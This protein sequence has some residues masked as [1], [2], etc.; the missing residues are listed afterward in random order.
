M[1]RSSGRRPIL[2]RTGLSFVTCSLALTAALSAA[3]QSEGFT[4]CDVEVGGQPVAMVA[5]DLDRDGDVDLAIVD[6]AQSRV[7]LLRADRDQVAFDCR[8]ALPQATVGVVNQPVAIA[9]GDV[10]SNGTIDLVVAGEAG[11]TILRGDGGGGFTGDDLRAAGINPQAVSIGSV[12]GDAA[13]DIVVGNGF[14]STVTVLIGPQFDPAKS[15]KFDL[16]NPAT[17]IYVRDL[18]DD[19]FDDVAVLLISGQLG[20]LLQDDSAA[21]DLRP[22]PLVDVIDAPTAMALGRLTLP[23]IGGSQAKDLIPDVAV[24]GAG[25]PGT[26]SYYRGQ[27]PGQEADAFILDGGPTTVGD[28]PSSLAFGNFNDDAQLDVAVANQADNTVELFAGSADGQFSELDAKCERESA[29]LLCLTAA[30]PRAI[31]V[32][33][34]DG[35]GFDDVITANEQAASIT[36]LLSRPDPRPP[37]P[38]ITGTPTTTATLTPPPSLTPTPPAPPTATFTPTSTA[39]TPTS[40][41]PHSCCVI[42][43]DESGCTDGPGMN[44]CADCIRAVDAFCFA[45]DGK[46]D[47]N[48]VNIARVNCDQ[49]CQCPDITPTPTVTSTFTPTRTSPPTSTPTPTPTATSTFTQDIRTQPSRTPTGTRPTATNTPTPTNTPTDTPTA[50]RTATLTRTPT[51]TP[52]PTSKCAGSPD[53]C[54]EGESCA[55]GSGASQ[56]AILWWVTPAVMFALSRRRRGSFL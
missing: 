20:V 3:A 36:I 15:L 2:V 28:S 18:N 32:A 51:I 17:A 13:P 30:G 22:L 34:I 12:N 42:R 53:I 24:L 10:D 9:A 8:G 41:P 4:S 38:T 11:V 50:T 44:G 23:P 31:A 26:I 45:E 29:S 7:I 6:Q 39:P 40:T 54:V 43:E 16:G 14:G 56:G 5:V 52:S 25:A 47:A 35:D 33:D 46:F 1:M 21:N 49:Q 48:C 19:T 55:I 27:L 37:T